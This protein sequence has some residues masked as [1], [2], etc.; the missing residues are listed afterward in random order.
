MPSWPRDLRGLRPL[1]P[2]LARDARPSGLVAPV[3]LARL[4]SGVP[5]VA[6]RASAVAVHPALSVPGP[7][8]ARRGRRRGGMG[9]VSDDWYGDWWMDYARARDRA[10]TWRRSRCCTGSCAST[11]PRGRTTGRL[12]WSTGPRASGSSCAT[13][14]SGRRAWPATLATNRP[15]PRT[16]HQR[17]TTNADRACP[18]AQGRADRG[19]GAVSFFPSSAPRGAA[20]T[21]PQ[22][23]WLRWERQ[24]RLFSDEGDLGL[25]PARLYRTA[26]PPL[27]ATP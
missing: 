21:I 19:R 13:K 10:A 16:T 2:C 3:P 26:S 4:S 9:G 11:S 15:S 17:W 1:R 8:R 25:A 14:G 6:A 18:G 7:H 23:K 27:A 22:G 24:R 20:A 5:A 12:R